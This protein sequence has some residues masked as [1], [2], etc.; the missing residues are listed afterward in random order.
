[1]IKY[2]EKEKEKRVGGLDGRWRNNKMLI[3]EFSTIH[4]QLPADRHP[5]QT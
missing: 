3:T 5:D 1:M 4:T 2:G